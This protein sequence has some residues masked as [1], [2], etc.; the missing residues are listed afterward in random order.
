MNI[1]KTGPREIGFVLWGHCQNLLDDPRSKAKSYYVVSH[2][3]KTT[4]LQKNMIQSWREGADIYFVELRIN[5]HT[6]VL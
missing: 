3:F 5:A 6:L 2:F 1:I 4:L